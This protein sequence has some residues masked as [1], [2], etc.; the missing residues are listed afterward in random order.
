[1]VIGDEV[2]IRIDNQRLITLSATNQSTL[3]MT[4]ED[5]HNVAIVEMHSDSVI[6][7]YEALE[8]WIK[9]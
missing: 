1:M 2:Q 7:L 5:P 4:V 6:P 3:I 9:R 8:D